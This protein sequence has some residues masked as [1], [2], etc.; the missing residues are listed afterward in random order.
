MSNSAVDIS[1]V[2]KKYKQFYHEILEGL[3]STPKHLPSKYFYDE[4]GDYL[5]QKIMQSSEYYLTRSEKEI[6]QYQSRDIAEK[7]KTEGDTFD[8]VGLGAGDGSKSIFLIDAL[9]QQGVIKNYCPVDISAHVISLLEQ[10]IPQQ[11]TGVNVC[12]YHGEYLDMLKKISQDSRNPKLVL[13]LGSNIGNFTQKESIRFLQQLR[14]WLNLGDLLFIG[15]DLKKYP[16]TIL[17]AYNDNKGYTKAFNLNMLERINRELNATFRVSNF[18]HYPVYDP[19]TG[20]CKSF[21]ISLQKQEVNLGNETIFF[22]KDEPVLM[23]VSQKYQL[24]DIDAMAKEC[25]CEIIDYF[26]DEKKWFADV[27]WRCRDV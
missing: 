23:E 12:G 14:K 25:G 8:V 15:F 11:I 20:V 22:E 1:P 6:L 4:T 2:S 13:F 7:V 16:Q 18:D 27:L 9:F 17:D 3:T 26:F 21:L 10:K 19:A 5:F 24:E